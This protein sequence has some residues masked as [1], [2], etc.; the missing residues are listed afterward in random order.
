MRLLFTL[1]FFLLWISKSLCQEKT[2]LVT[3]KFENLTES[4]I[5]EKIESNTNF[6]FFYIDE[7]LGQNLYSG[8]FKEASIIII[9]DAIFSNSDLN[10]TI[11]EKTKIILTQNN[12]IYNQLPEGFFGDTIQKS[13]YV[14]LTPT[15]SNPVLVKHL[16]TIG[17]C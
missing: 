8:D 3:L 15:V 10:Y 5:I 9:L 14:A 16:Q 1:S 11:L 13:T 12:L 17:L 4:Q 2:D 6:N 7:W